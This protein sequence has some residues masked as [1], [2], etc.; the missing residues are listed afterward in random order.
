MVGAVLAANSKIVFQATVYGP[1]EPGCAIS[2]EII[3]PSTALLGAAK[4]TLCPNNRNA[5][6]AARA[7][8]ATLDADVKATCDIFADVDAVNKPATLTPVEVVANLSVPSLY[9]FVVP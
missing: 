7:S 8:H 6:A 9:N 1:P 3:A 2:T 5:F 4:V